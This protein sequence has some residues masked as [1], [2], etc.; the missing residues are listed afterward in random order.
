MIEVARGI[1]WQ[2]TADYDTRKK[3]EAGRRLLRSAPAAVAP[4]RPPWVT[5][6]YK[7]YLVYLDVHTSVW[8]WAAVKAAVE[9]DPSGD[10]LLD[11]LESWL[12]EA[13]PAWRSRYLDEAGIPIP[14]SGEPPL[15]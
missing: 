2:L 6:N 1:V 11:D 12:D 8:L 10:A 13:E 7:N 15:P 5:D 14:F 9:A 4:M 3:A